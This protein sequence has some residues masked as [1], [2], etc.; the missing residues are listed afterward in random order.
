MPISNQRR[1]ERGWNQTEIICEAI[2]SYDSKK[3][4]QYTPHLLEKIHHTES[5]TKTANKSE[6]SKNLL[7]TMGIKDSSLVTGKIVVVVDDVITTGSTFAEAR[8]VL[9]GANRILCV[10]VAH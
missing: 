2:K 3:I 10:A 7:N 1:F 6:R 9:A 5:Q 4:L 8:R